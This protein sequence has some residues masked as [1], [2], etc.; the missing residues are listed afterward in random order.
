MMLASPDRFVTLLGAPG[1]FEELD[2]DVIGPALAG[3]PVFNGV[4]EEDA[5]W[6]ADVVATHEFLEDLGVDSVLVE[7]PGQG[8]ELD[9]SFDESIFFEFWSTH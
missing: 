7:F 3:K 1:Y 2:A 6:H 4:G 5:G 8:H 9:E